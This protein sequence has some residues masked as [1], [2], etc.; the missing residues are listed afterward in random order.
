MERIA[1]INKL[2]QDCASL[3][4]YLRL[5]HFVSRPPWNASMSQESLRHRTSNYRHRAEMKPPLIR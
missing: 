3:P 1:R 5:G 2:L 4:P